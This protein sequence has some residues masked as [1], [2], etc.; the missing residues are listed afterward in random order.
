MGCGRMLGAELQTPWTWCITMLWGHDWMNVCSGA[1]RSSS[2]LHNQ[3]CHHHMIITTSVSI[4]TPSNPLLA[5]H[6][7]PTPPL[8][9]P[10][11]SCP[12]PPPPPSRLL[13]SP[14]RVL[15]DWFS[16]L[17]GLL[18]QPGSGNVSSMVVLNHGLHDNGMCML[19]SCILLCL[20]ACTCGCT[21]VGV[22]AKCTN[23]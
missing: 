19:P 20:S 12:L 9:L 15:S 7:P 23:P 22:R 10:H 13:W 8:I 21:S 18:R 11:S 6:L 17:S 16:A 4:C 3:H 1:C 2:S 14:M 5:L